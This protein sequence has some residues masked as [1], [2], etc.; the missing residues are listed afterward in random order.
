M[1]VLINGT[2]SLRFVNDRPVQL[3][4]HATVV[5]AVALLITVMQPQTARAQ[6]G[7]G[8]GGGWHGGGGAWNG[9]SWHQGWYGSRYGLRLLVCCPGLWLVGLRRAGLHLI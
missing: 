7:G 6:H 3:S 2:P 9:G 4:P 1:F 5:L 8:G